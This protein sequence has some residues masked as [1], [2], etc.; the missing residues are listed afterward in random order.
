MPFLSV[1]FDEAQHL[2]ILKDRLFGPAAGINRNTKQ[3][4]HLY[5]NSMPRRG[6]FFVSNIKLSVN[7][8]PASLHF[9]QNYPSSVSK[10]LQ[11]W[12]RALKDFRCTPWLLLCNVFY[13]AYKRS[14]KL[15][16]IDKISSVSKHEPKSSEKF[17]H[18]HLEMDKYW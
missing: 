7:I 1:L 4:R 13:H 2:I 6:H 17:F 11:S 16:E 12:C 15:L 8:G 10:T 18:F 9:V 14:L 5:Y 3:R